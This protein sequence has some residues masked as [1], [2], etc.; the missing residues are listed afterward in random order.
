MITLGAILGFSCSRQDDPRK[1]E[2]ERLPRNPGIPARVVGKMKVEKARFFTQADGLP[3]DRVSSLFV[4]GSG[5]VLAGTA[6]GL[7]ELHADPGVWSPLPGL[8]LDPVKSLVPHGDGALAL[9][10]RD[11]YQIEGASRR[12]AEVPQEISFGSDP[13]AV[14]GGKTVYLGSAKGLYRLSGLQFVPV[15]SLNGMI[16]GDKKIVQLSRSPDGSRVLVSSPNGLYHRKATGGW[17][18]LQ[19]EIDGEPIA[20]EDVRF[21]YFARDGKIGFGTSDGVG[22]FDGESWNFLEAKD[23]LPYNDFTVATDGESGI[24]WFGT[25]KG[26]IRFDGV[27]WEYRQGKRWLPHDRVESITVTENGDAWIATPEG[28]SFIQR[29]PMTLWEKA[30]F[31]ESEID[32]R[33]RRTEFGFVNKVRL[34]NPGDKSRWFNWESDNDGLW[35]SLYGASQAFAYAATSDPLAKENA[36]RALRAVSFLSQVNQGGEHPAQTGFPARSILPV[37]GENPNIR[38]TLEKD[39]KKRAEKDSLWKVMWPRWPLSEDGNWYWKCDTSSDELDGH[40]FFYAL[41]YD[42]VAETEAEK[43]SVRKVVKAMTDHL[44]RND[45][46]LVDWDGLPTRWANFS[47]NSLNKDPNWWEERGLNSL[48]MLSHLKVAEHVTQNPYYGRV[49]QELIR[50]HGYAMNVMVPKIQSG[51][52]TGNQSDDEMAFMAY[53]SLLQYERN[54]ALREIYAYSFFQYWQLEEPERNPFFNYMYAAVASNDKIK[55]PWEEISFE[56]KGDWMEDSVDALRRYPLDLIRWR[57]QHS[58]RLDIVLLKDED[59]RGRL[60]NGNV[61]PLD[62]RYTKNWAK[63]PWKLD[64]G[65][66]EGFELA[67]AVPYLI[68]YYMGLYHGFLEEESRNH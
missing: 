1:V 4:T 26:A 27:N 21:S 31:Y 46:R 30:K 64:K 40:Y 16:D 48:S 29:I 33:H 60:Q 25:Q 49:A 41:Y 12:V 18:K 61:L 17:E 50:D 62:E 9:L 11:L 37:S 52:G 8:P 20:L 28:I 42:L 67:D 15:Y 23:G 45:F 38:Q 43:E 63:D 13:V 32:L 53:Y 56:P 57:Y 14:L 7:A 2:L 65:G 58:H 24:R 22:Q 54:P 39:R 47:P 66:T 6:S 55:T 34:E 36:R 44:I 19:P 3:S 35:T 10:G 51:P 59:D 5:Q 68:G